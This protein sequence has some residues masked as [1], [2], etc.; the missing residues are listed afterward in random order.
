[1]PKRALRGSV[2]ASLDVQED[3]AGGLAAVAFSSEEDWSDGF[4]NPPWCGEEKLALGFTFYDQQS[5]QSEVVHI[6]SVRKV[7]AGILFAEFDAILE[8]VTGCA[9]FRGDGLSGL[10]CDFE[11]LAGFVADHR[12]SFVR[13]DFDGHFGGS[14]ALDFAESL[15]FMPHESLTGLSSHNHFAAGGVFLG[16]FCG[17]CCGV[18]RSVGDGLSGL[19]RDG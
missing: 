8:I 5:V 4:R 18:N 6:G 12:G 14:A 17:I 11:G 19:N 2:R 15:G 3:G 9:D 7:A 1:M 13:Q 10:D 16:R